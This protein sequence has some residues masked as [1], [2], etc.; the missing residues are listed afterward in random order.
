[1]MAFRMQTEARDAFDLNKEPRRV[2][3]AYGPGYFADA[4]LLA[5]RL[6]ERGVRMVQ[7]YTGD[8]QPWDDHGN[9]LDHRAKAQQADRPTSAG[10]SSGAGDERPGTAAGT[11]AGPA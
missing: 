2:R 6:V 1:E 4:C 8:G 11:A 7:I 5:R 10:P 3:D 9:I